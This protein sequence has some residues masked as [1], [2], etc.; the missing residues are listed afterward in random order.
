M[1]IRAKNT[2]SGDFKG[3][4]QGNYIAVCDL[5]ADFGLQPGSA[6]YPDPKYQVYIRFAV[7]SETIEYEK[8]GKKISGPRVIGNAYTASMGKKANLR[9]MVQNWLGR[10]FA[11]EDEA[12]NFDISSL[13]GKG[14]MVN[15]IV[16]E[17]GEKTY[18]NIGSIS[19]LPKGMPPPALETLLLVY[20][21]DHAANLTK[22]PEW[23]QEKIK[24][25]LKP[26]MSHATGVYAESWSDEPSDMAGSYD[27]TPVPLEAYSD[28]PYGDGTGIG[29]SDIPPF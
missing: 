29:D 21:E 14:C 8:D 26:E 7:P 22:L 4:P 9:K 23:M 20:D 16:K 24:G 13:L 3:L 12:K 18:S 2:G 27:F 1:A 28:E 15:V 25:Q 5:I 11:S 17:V 19:A 10:D 6:Q